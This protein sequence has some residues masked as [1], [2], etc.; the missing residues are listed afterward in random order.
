MK[1]GLNDTAGW[2]TFLLRPADH[3]FFSHDRATC[4]ILREAEEE[5]EA[6][7]NI[8]EKAEHRSKIRLQASSCR[9]GKEGKDLEPV[10]QT[11]PLASSSNWLWF[12]MKQRVCAVQSVCYMWEGRKWGKKERKKERKRRRGRLIHTL[13]NARLPSLSI[14]ALI[15]VLISQNPYQ[16]HI[17][18]SPLLLRIIRGIL[19]KARK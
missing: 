8:S 11:Q 16:S 5:E 2:L 19:Q 13:A 7:R 12:H 10:K 14:G 18:H 15:I 6:W 17:L 4:K 1:A 9:E 3:N